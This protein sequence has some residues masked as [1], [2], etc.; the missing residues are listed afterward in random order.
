[1]FSDDNFGIEIG[2]YNEV[3]E[4]LGMSVLSGI[5]KFEVYNS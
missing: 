3:N 5:S 2:D 1:M 4:I